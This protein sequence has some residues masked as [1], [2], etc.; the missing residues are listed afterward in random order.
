MEATVTAG[1]V[2]GIDLP[3]NRM[4][5]GHDHLAINPI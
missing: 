2:N 1:A 4:S 3:L 5:E